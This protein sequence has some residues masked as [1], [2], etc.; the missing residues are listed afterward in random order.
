M[1]VKVKYKFRE[2][3][4]ATECT[5]QLKIKVIYKIHGKLLPVVVKD[6]M[7]WDTDSTDS[8]LYLAD[9]S[10]NQ[11]MRRKYILN[12]LK[13]H[14]KKEED[15]LVVSSVLETAYGLFSKKGESFS[16]SDKELGLIE[17]KKENEVESV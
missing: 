6:E 9:F 7:Y 14:F 16:F 11:D 2:L 4:W 17:D 1:E 15:N 3:D 8:L 10:K 5:H 12:M 13:N